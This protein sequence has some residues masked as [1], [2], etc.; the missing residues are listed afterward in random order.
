MENMKRD[1]WKKRRNRKNETRIIRAECRNREK[2][3]IERHR[4]KY[5]KETKNVERY[6]RKRKSC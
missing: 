4:N 1:L 5:K 6:T 3:K 2:D